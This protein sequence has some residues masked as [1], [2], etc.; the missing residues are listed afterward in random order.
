MYVHSMLFNEVLG[1]LYLK[2]GQI[3]ALSS[4][5]ACNDHCRGVQW[6]YKCSDTR[7][8]PLLM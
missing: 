4:Y 3:L 6:A 5:Q 8:F 1:Q 7:K 2:S